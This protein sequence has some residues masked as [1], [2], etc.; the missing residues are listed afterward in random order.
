MGV[1]IKIAI[2]FIFVRQL[3]NVY[4][5]LNV[6]DF[7]H[8]GAMA[9]GIISVP[10]ANQLRCSIYFDVHLLAPLTLFCIFV[11]PLILLLIDTI[12]CKNK[13]DLDVW[14]KRWKSGNMKT[15]R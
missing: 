1:F 3:C 9:V 5:I 2:D 14:K 15:V 4:F 10:F 13:N 12:K 11:I 8:R 6:V 7:Y